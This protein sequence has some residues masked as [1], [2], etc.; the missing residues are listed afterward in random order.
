MP[1]IGL[2]IQ[3]QLRDSGLVSTNHSPG[4]SPRIGPRELG[5]L[6]GGPLGRRAATDGPA[7][8]TLAARVR[9]LVLDGRLPV[10][11]RL[12]PE[13]ELAA[14]LGISRA[15]VSAGYDRLRASGHAVSRRGAGTWTSVPASGAPV[16]AWADEPAPAGVLDLAHAAPSAPPQLH[17][18]YAAALDE[19]PRHLPGTG[20]DYRGLASLR[21]AIAD[22]FTAR[23]LPTAPAQV[24]VTSGALQAIRLALSLAVGPGDRVLV[25]QPGYPNA[26]DVVRDVGGRA[27]PVPVDPRARAWDVDALLAA[28]RQAV[29]RAAYLVPDFQNPT[30]ALLPDDERARV[31]RALGRAQAL[32]VVDETHVELALDGRPMPRPFAAHA[33]STTVVTVGSMSKVGWGGLRVGWLRADAAT[34]TRLAALRSRQDLGSPLVE[35]LACRHLLADLDAVRRHRVGELRAARDLLLRL[36]AHWLPQWRASA[37]PGGQALWCELP[38]PS[39][40]GLVAAATDLGLRLTSGSRFAASGTLESWVRLPYTR[41]PDQLGRA[42]PLLARAWGRLGA[43]AVGPGPTDSWVV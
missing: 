30:G 26:L 42:V 22:R 43:D 6:L 40:G 3:G 39:S 37:P 25:E 19:L 4:R 1:K 41:P 34:T 35:Q 18:A 38:S 21:S 16:P 10:G 12:P 20:Y 13:R 32:V 8:A 29:P 9:L 11:V 7:Y 27:V 36:L 23:G 14:A 31:A 17:A 5:R 28:A 24:L 15:T 2:V 33:R